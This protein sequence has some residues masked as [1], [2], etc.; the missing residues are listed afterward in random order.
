MVWGQKGKFCRHPKFAFLQAS[1]ALFAR[2]AAPL[3][4]KI[5]VSIVIYLLL[6][7]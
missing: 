5:K 3:T 7:K 6:P 4:Q 1:Q 2:G